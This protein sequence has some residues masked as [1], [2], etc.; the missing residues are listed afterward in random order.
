ML[1]LGSWHGMWMLEGVV[2]KKERKGEP[3]WGEHAGR[4]NMLKRGSDKT[5]AKFTTTLPS[6]IFSMEKRHTFFTCNMSLDKLEKG[7]FF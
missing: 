3:N 1:V 6:R 4:I 7:D 5:L 2:Q